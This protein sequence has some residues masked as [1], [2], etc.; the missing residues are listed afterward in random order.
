MNQSQAA[1]LEKLRLRPFL[2]KM[3]IKNYMEDGKLISAKVLSISNEDILQAFKKG[4]NNMT[5]LSLGS[6]HVIPSAVPH[7]FMNAFKN[8]A[9]VGIAADYD[10]E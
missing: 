3:K 9:C 5:A 6:G 8:L 1:L 4:V 2:Y 10:F 7:L